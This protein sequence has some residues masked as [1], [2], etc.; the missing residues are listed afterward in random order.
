MERQ[1]REVRE[2]LSKLQHKRRQYSWQQAEGI[3]TDEE[4][5]VA[6]KQ[7]RAEE[8]ILKGQLKRLEELSDEP[9]PPDRATFA[10]LASYWRGP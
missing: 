1:I 4:L 8:G 3:I 7:L 10:K 2:Q 6:H 9:S 5:L